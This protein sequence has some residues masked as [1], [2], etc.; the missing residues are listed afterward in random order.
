MKTKEK[1]ISAVVSRTTVE[2]LDRLAKARGLKKGYVIEAALRQYLIALRELPPEFIIPPQVVVS[3][4]SAP[5]ILDS[6]RNP[7][8]PS[9]ELRKLMRGEPVS[10]DG[11]D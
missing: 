7:K 11:L 3:S 10:D 5:E 2:L 8:P 4:E 1:Q 9:P 6:I